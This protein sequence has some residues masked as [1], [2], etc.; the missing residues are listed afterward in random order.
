MASQDYRWTEETQIAA[1]APSQTLLLSIY[2]RWLKGL[3]CRDSRHWEAAWREASRSLGQDAGRDALSALECLLR[4]IAGHALR[5]VSYHP[6]C[7]GY[8]AEDECLLLEAVAAAGQRESEAL[9]AQLV[10]A[11]GLGAVGQAARDLSRAFAAGGHALPRLERS[12]A[13]QQGCDVYAAPARSATL[14]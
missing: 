8:L 1:L 4:R 2:R 3:E 13:A 6:P 7:C 14:H 10:G 12:L 9:F 5:S 11:Q